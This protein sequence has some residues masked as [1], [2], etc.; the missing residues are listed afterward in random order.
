M[1][2]A[3]ITN[4]DTGEELVVGDDVTVKMYWGKPVSDEE[5]VEV[6]P[7][8]LA[9]PKAIEEMQA[10]IRRALAKALKKPRKKSR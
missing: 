8:F 3:T 6:S 10:P 5:M 7:G 1:D 9:D 2:K 4:L